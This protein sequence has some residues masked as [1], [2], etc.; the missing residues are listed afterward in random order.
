MT[1]KIVF[2]LRLTD[3]S[4]ARIQAVAPD[5]EIVHGK[6]RSVWLPH[7]KTAEIIGGWNRK[8]EE[9][10]LGTE[11]SPLRWI[12]NWGAGVDR[13]PLQEFKRRGIIVTNASGVHA[14]PVSETAWAMMLAWTRKLH[15]YVRNQSQRM[16]GDANLSLELHG[17][18]LGV[19]GVGAI[20]EEI[21][22]LGKAFGMQTYGLRRSGQPSA[23]IDRMYGREGLHELL[24]QCDYVVNVLPLT[25]DTRRL[26][27]REQFACMKE[28]A[29]YVSVGRGGATDETA[30]IEALEDG[31]IAGAGL[32]VFETEPLAADSPLWGMDNVIITPHSSGSTGRYDERVIDIFVENLHACRDGK[33]PSVNRVDLDLQY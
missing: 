20:G 16:W 3:E 23:W 6:D 25:D 11:P 14:F 30:L 5:R 17:S 2:V 31:R 15:I 27:G 32:D 26:M 18:R 7:V 29:F 24:A 4:L 22:R 1:G 28:S 33:T 12:H 10:C 21:A 13:M 9:A 19:L 8:V